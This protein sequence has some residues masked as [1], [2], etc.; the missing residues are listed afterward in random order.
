MPNVVHTTTTF[1]KLLAAIEKKGL[2]ITMP[3]PGDKL[4]AGMIK[5]TVLAP[6]RKFDDMNDMSIVVRMTHGKTAILFT[7]DATAA[8][9]QE[10]LK[11]G[12]TL[13]AD[14]LKAGH[15]GSRSS[16]TP[17]FLNAVK[18]SIVV[19][20]CGRENAYKLPHPQFLAT[21]GQPQRNITLLRTDELGTIILKTDGQKIYRLGLESLNVLDN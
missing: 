2:K 7:G 6:L 15:H 16:T 10:M 1:E 5:L 13:R 4:T 3:K 11:S 9:E 21:V 14:V 20:S 19:V 18:P 17:A 12:R 8:S